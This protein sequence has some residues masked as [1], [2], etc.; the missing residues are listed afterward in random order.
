ME[1]V[2]RLP[3]IRRRDQEGESNDWGGLGLCGLGTDPSPLLRMTTREGR[4]GRDSWGKEGGALGR[5]HPVSS[6]HATVCVMLPLLADVMPWGTRCLIQV[7]R[8][9]SPRS[10]Y[11][12]VVGRYPS[13]KSQM[14]A[15]LLTSGSLCVE[16]DARQ[17]MA[18]M[19][20]R[21]SNE[22]PANNS[23]E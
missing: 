20:T 21:K 4:M 8:Y 2:R 3:T 22:T 15:R 17:H 10:S 12:R 13:E 11:L 1:R 5:R 7:V 9:P 6:Y 18:G 19:T 23:Q 16:Q 14:D